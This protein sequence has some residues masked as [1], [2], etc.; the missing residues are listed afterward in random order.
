MTDH[1][2]IAV[3]GGGVIGCAVAW[4][5]SER[6]DGVFLFEKNSGI[7]QGENQSSRNSGVIHSGIYSPIVLDCDLSLR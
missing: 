3:I 1:I 2:H 4:E 6:Y 5:L 7:T